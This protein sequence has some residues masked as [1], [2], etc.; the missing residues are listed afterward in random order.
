MATSTPTITPEEL[1]RRMAE[2]QT[3]ACGSAALLGKFRD[4]ATCILRDLHVSRWLGDE[5]LR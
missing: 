4:S 5:E 2:P 1:A 3:Y